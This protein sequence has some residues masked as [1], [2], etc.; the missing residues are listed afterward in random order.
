M[1]IILAEE[2]AGQQNAERSFGQDV[3]LVGRDAFECDIAFDNAQYPMVSRKHAELRWAGG[4]WAIIDLNS[5]YGTFVNGV[6][7]SGSAI[8]EVGSSIQFG[9][10][11]PILRVVWFELSQSN[12]DV[13]IAAASP[14]V[15]HDPSPPAEA[16]PAVYRLEFVDE[17]QRPPL[18]VSDGSLWLGRDP[19]CNVVFDASSATVSRKHAE[20]I[21]GHDQLSVVDNNSFNGTLVNGHRISARTTLS[22]GDTIQLGMGGPR[23]CV[24]SA[25]RP[26]PEVAARVQHAIAPPTQLNAPTD[27]IS[28]KTMVV[29]LQSVAG[30]ARGKEFNEPQ[31]LMT[32]SFPQTGTLIIG[33]D[34]SNDIR[35][36]GLQISK[37]HAKLIRT[38]AGIGVED[39]G[40]TNGVFINGSRV[41]RGEVSFSDSIQIGSFVIRVDQGHQVLVYDTRSKTRI[42][43]IGVMTEVKDR[44]R[45]GKVR[46]LDEVSLSIKPNEFIGLIGPSG[47]GKSTL[48]EAL[49][50][51]RPAT[52]GS[53]LINKLDLY[54]HFDSLKQA[55]GY[56]PQDDII[57]RELTVYRTLY[58]VAKLRLSRDVTSN[59]IAKM[60]D[61]VL[62]VT[63]LAERRDTPVRQLSGGQRKRVSIAVELVTKPSVIFLDEPTSGLDPATEGKIMRLFK[64]IADSGRTV[65]M[66]THA[67]GNVKLFDKIVVLVRGRLVFYGEPDDA[68]KHLGVKNFDELYRRL[69]DPSETG[70]DSRDSIDRVSA[71]ERTADE[72]KRKY[73]ATPQF[74][75]LIE[76]PLKELSAGHASGTAKRRRL[77]VFGS[78][79]QWLTLSRRYIEVLL[80][81]RS[82]LFILLAQAPIIAAMTYLIMG[83]EQPRDFVYFVVSLVALWF[84]TSVAAREI[85]RERPIY[86]RERMFNLGILPYLGSKIF[87]L[88]LI[89]SVQCFLLFVP[90][91]LLDLSG[92]M[93]MPGE[94]GGIPQFWAM[95]LTSSVGVALGLL[96]SAFV[97][98]SEMATSLVPLLL[99]PQ[100]L[101]SGLV[102]VPTGLNKVVGLTMPSAW[103]FDTMKRFSTLD[104]LEPEGA[105]PRGKTKGMG[106][107]KFVETEN[108]KIISNA[109]RDL[110]D[111]K[112][113]AGPNYQA[114]TS[115]EPN[116]LSDRLEVPEMKKVPDDLSSYISYLHPWM[117]EV[118]NQVVLMLMFGIMTILSVIVFRLKDRSSY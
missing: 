39:L 47:A 63:G 64:Q 56:V 37:R 90:L 9:Q 1:N 106:L 89:V 38:S 14:K 71:I 96:V 114:D 35:L 66:T 85:I 41:T 23:L 43:V 57:H 6:R 13:E 86:K 2:S 100:I 74:K 48:I 78:I 5:S 52:S 88:G 44:S 32:A 68:L 20:I 58:Y 93:P 17:S 97:K 81:D 118:L 92:L 101:F 3:I 19:S 69:D 42:D 4:Q 49:N 45:G 61:E 91:K 11:G 87:V 95:L 36:D 33:R 110:E 115:Q 84:G 99:I 72:L 108:E 7:I 70:A 30:S 77:G 10:D 102:G 65:V 28:S 21:A 60:I 54:R 80:K 109:K 15:I 31:L 113:I 116:P 34:E 67:M 22:D 62:D 40:S 83:A 117:N 79:R 27:P 12:A 76:E 16:R 82:N 55:I 104:T 24:V 29:S 105:N 103:S 75:E 8:L 25:A 50:G 98:T 94:F 73:Q 59:E 53:V 107:Y 51:V 112:R 18:S 26:T 111:F 46:L